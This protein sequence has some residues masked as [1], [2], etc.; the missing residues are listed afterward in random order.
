MK[1]NP[2]KTSKFFTNLRHALEDHVQGTPEMRLEGI[3]S[4]WFNM[5]IDILQL[6]RDIF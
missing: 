6:N 2:F 1:E 3:S 4:A 5:E